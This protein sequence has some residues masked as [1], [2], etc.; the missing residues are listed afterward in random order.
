MANESF[1]TKEGIHFHYKR[2]PL[3]AVY[4]ESI[5]FHIKR[6][7]YMQMRLQQNDDWTKLLPKV[8]ENWNKSK[9][10]SL[11]YLGMYI[12]FRFNCTIKK[13]IHHKYSPN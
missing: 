11:G 3:K 6:R 9:H 7:L 2:N 10:P 8:V 13:K 4:I 1:F 5:I 12:F